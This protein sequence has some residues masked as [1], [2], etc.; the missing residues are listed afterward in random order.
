MCEGIAVAE[1]Q[2]TERFYMRKYGLAIQ[3]AP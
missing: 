2:V 3:T 1:I